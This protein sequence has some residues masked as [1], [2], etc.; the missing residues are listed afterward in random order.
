MRLFVDSGAWIA[1]YD[2]RDMRHQE[3]AEALRRL[4]G[5]PVNLV[6]SR[7]VIDEVLTFL[8]LRTGHAAAVAFGE[9]V[10]SADT[11]TIFAVDDDVWAAAWNL[12]RRYD[13]KIFSFTDCTSFIIMQQL[14]LWEAFSFDKNFQQMGFRLW[15]GSLSENEE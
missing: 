7:Y 15:P 11:V 2:R 13:D 3:A 6:T 5:Q 9:W 12:F 4:R 8:R 1:L 14:G 10:L